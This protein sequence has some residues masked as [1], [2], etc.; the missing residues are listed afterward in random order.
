MENDKANK[1]ISFS[2]Y[3]AKGEGQNYTFLYILKIINTSML[4]IPVFLLLSNLSCSLIE[5]KKSQLSTAT[6]F[7]SMS[8][9][10]IR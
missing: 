7:I 6:M 10:V 1:K 4:N 3:L 9:S 8:I 2:D 5:L